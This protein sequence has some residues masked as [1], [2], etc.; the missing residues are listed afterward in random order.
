MKKAIKVLPFIPFLINLISIIFIFHSIQWGVYIGTT[1]LLGLTGL[2]I[3]SN[4]K[5]LKGI[6]VLS[7]LIFVI[8]MFQ[9][10]QT[11]YIPMFSVKIS[12]AC[13]VYF[14]IIYFLKWK[15]SK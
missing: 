5:I 4:Q 11:D 10:G 12:I 6:G 1:I 13:V 3:A 8:W 9:I 7:L 2:G 14:A 15:L